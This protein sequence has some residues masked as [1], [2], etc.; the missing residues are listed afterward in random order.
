MSTKSSLLKILSDN[1]GNYV[2]G[3]KIG[4]MLNVSR[5]A[6]NKACTALREQGYIIES[7]TNKGYMLSEHGKML[8][9][10]G[11]SAYIDVPCG[12]A[13]EV[14]VSQIESNNQPSLSMKDLIQFITTSY[15]SSDMNVREY[16]GNLEIPYECRQRIAKYLDEVGA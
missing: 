14:F 9:V 15:S 11:T 13:E 16:F 12:S 7:R 10:D 1:A 8:T 6:V 5:T 3:E 2:S 4:E